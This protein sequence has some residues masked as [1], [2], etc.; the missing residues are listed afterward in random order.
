MAPV[1]TQISHIKLYRAIHISLLMLLMLLMLLI[2]LVLLKLLM[3]ILDL[4]VEP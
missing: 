1:Y 3:L 4:A 2:L